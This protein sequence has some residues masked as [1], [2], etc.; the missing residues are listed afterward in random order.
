MKINVFTYYIY[1]CLMFFLPKLSNYEDKFNYLFQVF[2]VFPAL[3]YMIVVDLSR[4]L[5]DGGD[6]ACF[7]FRYNDS[8]FPT[9]M[10]SSRPT[11]FRGISDQFPLCYLLLLKTKLYITI[12]QLKYYNFYP[13]Y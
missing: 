8:V 7:L 5:S 6:C 1:K 10:L 13:V 9:T 4:G 11:N 12:F 3:M 2:Y